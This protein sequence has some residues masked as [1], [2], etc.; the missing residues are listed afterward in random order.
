[1]KMN[2]INK[3]SDKELEKLLADKRAAIRQ[4]RFDISGSK[5]KN[6]KEGANIRKD[7]ARILTE[8]SLRN[9]K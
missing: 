7:V 8:L 6:L 1:M 9:K 4:F 2:D 5:A 3:Q